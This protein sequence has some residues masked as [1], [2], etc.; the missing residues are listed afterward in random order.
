MRI[1]LLTLLLVPVVM[2][3]QEV[4]PK[5]LPP[6]N[7]YTLR[8]LMAQRPAEVAPEQWRLVVGNPANATLFPIRLTQAMLDTLD[9][10]ELDPRYQ[11]VME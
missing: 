8:L 10:R 11:Y 7:E 4:A 2:L 3:A 6:V 9:A 1:L 5:G